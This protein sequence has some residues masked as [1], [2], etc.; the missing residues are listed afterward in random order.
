MYCIRKMVYDDIENVT[1]LFMESYKQTPW[2][3]LWKKEE[4]F[5]RI[6]DIFNFHKSFCYVYEYNHSIVGALLGF[7]LPWHSGKQLEIRELFIHPAFQN[8]GIG[9]KL[10]KKIEISAK[11]YG[12]KDIVL[13]TK[14]VSN[15]VHFYKTNNCVYETQFIHFSKHI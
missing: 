3:E 15:L 10:F 4:A 6:N 9:T 2:N 12:V 5:E 14:N 7:V 11:A 1:N 8:R 13:T